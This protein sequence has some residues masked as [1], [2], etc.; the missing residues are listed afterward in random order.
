MDNF[1]DRYQSVKLNQEQIHH[2]NN[3]ITPNEIEADIKGLPTKKSPGPDRFSAEFYQ[4]FVEDLIP[5]LSKLFQKVETDGALPNSFYEATITL[6]PKPHKDQTKKELQTN[7]PY[8][9]RCKN[10]Q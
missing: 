3:P 4:T 8:E 1:L 5:I 10:T 9:Y 7:F 6:L 2:L